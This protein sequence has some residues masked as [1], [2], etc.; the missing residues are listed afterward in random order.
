MSKGND[1]KIIEEDKTSEL[2]ESFSNII[3]EE[4]KEED[5]YSNS[6]NQEEVK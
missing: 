6:Y 2:K 3:E 5:D 4:D 1:S